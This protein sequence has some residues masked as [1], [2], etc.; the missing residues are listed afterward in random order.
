MYPKASKSRLQTKLNPSTVDLRP[1]ERNPV[2]AIENL[3]CR[4]PQVNQKKSMINEMHGCAYCL[5]ILEYT[6]LSNNG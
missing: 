6:P 4:L 5:S 1:K 2:Y 3:Q